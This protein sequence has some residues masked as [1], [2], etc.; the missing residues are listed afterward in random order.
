MRWLIALGLAFWVGMALGQDYPSKT[1]TLV[2]PFGAGG[3][4]DAEARRLAQFL[5]GN[6]NQSVL[7]ESRP[8]AAG[9]VGAE[10]VSRATPDGHTLLVGFAGM[11]TFRLLMKDVTFD[12]NVDL[13]PVSTLLDFPAGFVTNTQTPAK[14]IDEFIAY[15]KANPGKLNY[16]SIGR[17]DALLMTEALKR[18]TGI[19]LSEIAYGG[20]AQATTGLLR[21]DVQL[22]YNSFN[23]QLKAQADSGVLRPLLMIG[24][25]RAKVFPD[26]PTTAEKGWNIPAA[27]WIGIFAPPRTPPAILERAAAGIAAYD[28]SAH[29][30]KHGDDNGITMISMSPAKFHALIDS[31]ARTWAELAQAIGIKPE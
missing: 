25:R 22:G 2:V 13:A 28:A 31:G 3:P 5:Q 7:V 10:Y 23:L 16:A 4:I 21:N 12:P 6:W 29:A 26:V 9:R 19:Q 15:A 18:A 1:V 30:Q 24:E 17:G 27:G 14:T 11:N 8:G 20:V